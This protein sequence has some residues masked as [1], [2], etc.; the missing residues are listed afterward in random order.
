MTDERRTISAGAVVTPGRHGTRT[1]IPG[2]NHV[3]SC[4]CPGCAIC[5]TGRTAPPEPWPIDKIVV[6]CVGCARQVT[7]RM[8]LGSVREF[9][10]SDAG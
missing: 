7:S 2:T 3:L 9:N 5:E 6:R 8:P 1:P 4:E 10:V